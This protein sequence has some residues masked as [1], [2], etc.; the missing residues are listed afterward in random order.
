MIDGST[1]GGEILVVGSAGHRQL[2]LELYS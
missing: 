2:V 1:N